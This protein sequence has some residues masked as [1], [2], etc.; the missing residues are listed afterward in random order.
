MHGWMRRVLFLLRPQRRWETLAWTTGDRSGIR[1]TVPV[2]G[3]KAPER[4]TGSDEPEGFDPDAFASW[5]LETRQAPPTIEPELLEQIG[6]LLIG[7]F[8]ENIEDL[9]SFPELARRILELASQPDTSPDDFVNLVKEDPNLVLRV[10][11]VANSALYRRAQEIE[12]IQHAC[13][14]LGVKELS[15]I[16]TA[17]ASQGLFTNALLEKD[18]R[19]VDLAKQLRQQSL[20][21][22]FACAWFAS[23]LDEGDTDRAFLGGLLHD[24]GKMVALHALAALLESDDLEA[25]LEDDALASLLEAVHTDLGFEAISA[26]NLPEFLLEICQRHHGV[27]DLGEQA[28]P[29]LHVVRVA[30]GLDEI[31]TNPAYRPELADEVSESLSALG[32]S[33]TRIKALATE[34]AFFAENASAF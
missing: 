11:K 24:A 18:P 2:A 12:T 22:A 17:A 20:T 19:F 27:D 31:R 7:H 4:P 13:R 34:L 1:P 21:R 15:K 28:T 29:E 32:V 25:P 33:S 9:P 16:A 5:E 30:S 8:R 26:W 6:P 23:E 10:L 14:L 3:R